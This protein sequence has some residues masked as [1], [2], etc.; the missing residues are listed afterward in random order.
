MTTDR[1]S[2]ILSACRVER[3]VSAR[4]ALQAPWALRSDGLPGAMLRVSHGAPWWLLQDDLP[5]LRVHEGDL[6][7]LPHGSAHT[8]ASSPEVAATRFAELIARHADGRRDEHPLAFHHGGHGAATQVDS[9]LLWFSAWSRHAVLRQLPPLI[10]LRRGAAPWLATLVPAMQALVGDTLARGPGWRAAAGRM[11]E[12]AALQLVRDHLARAPRVGE[13][14][15]RGLQDPAIARALAAMHATPQRDWRLDTLAREAALS[16]SSFAERFRA[17]VGETPIGYLTAHRMALAAEQIESGRLPLS[18]IAEA[19]G[20]ESEKVFARA[21][22]RWS[23]LPPTRWLQRERARRAALL[24]MEGD[25][26]G[27]AAPAG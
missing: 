3:A 21:F 8:L 14:W 15:L 24:A 18:R 7:L 20:Y 11:G 17:L 16:R 5:P 23:G 25:A 12:L 22:R 19:A 10:H 13:G 2:E 1:L 4:F 6:I 9:V 27:A 26:G